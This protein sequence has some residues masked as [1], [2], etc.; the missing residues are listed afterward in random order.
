M[1]LGHDETAA[2]LFRERILMARGTDS[3]RAELAA[4]LGHLGEIDEARQVWQ[5]LML[6]NPDFSMRKR[7]DMMVFE[8]HGD[9][10]RVF[11]GLDKAG[12]PVT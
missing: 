11:E 6:I 4:A 1:M 7:M 9:V 2:M 3:G 8:G 10:S 5:D 12:L